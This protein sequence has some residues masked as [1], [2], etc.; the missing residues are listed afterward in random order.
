MGYTKIIQ[1]GDFLEVYRYEKNLPIRRK[2]R[3]PDTYR[4]GN[5]QDIERSPDS[6][7]RAARAFRRLVRANLAGDVPPALLTLTMHQ[8]L[9]Y[10]ASV[11][12]FTRFIARLRRSAGREFRYIAVPELQKRGS[13]HWHVLIWGL[14]HY[15][16][17]ERTTRYFARFW[18]RGFCDCVITDGHSKIASYLAKYLSK[19]MSNLRRSDTKT[20]YTS[21]NI[22]RPVSINASTLATYT[23]D[24]KIV[25]H[26]LTKL[27]YDTEW[28]GKCEYNSYKIEEI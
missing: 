23:K 2:I 1:S 8:K 21:R 10:A 13:W 4:K 16:Q 24:Q 17:E 7:R 11:R 5:R 3:S 19:A 27:E 9:S 12:I 14:G 15:A 20:Y 28:L 6:I 26:N 22:L 25:I 18:L